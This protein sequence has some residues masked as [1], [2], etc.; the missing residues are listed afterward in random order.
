EIRRRNA[1][2]PGD[3]FIV[4]ADDPDDLGYGDSYG[5]DQCLDLV[6]EALSSGRGLPAPEGWPTGQ[7]TAM[8]MIAT[9]PP[10]GHHAN[11]TVS[12]DADGEYTV[13]VGTAEFGNGTTTV[14]VQLVATE[15]ATA[16]DRV[17]VRQSDTAASGHDTGAFGSAGSVVAGKAVQV[18]AERLR[19]E[20]V[21]LAARA[22]GVASGHCA[23]RRDGVAL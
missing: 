14:H 13:A 10:R 16:P 21:T 7:G 12:V 1:V 15:L 5:L 3:P 23:I 19:A 4:T 6:G 9:I 11:V 8:A 22:A 18:A 2:V 20:L 17:R